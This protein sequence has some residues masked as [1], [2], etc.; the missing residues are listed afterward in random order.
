MEVKILIAVFSSQEF[1]HTR[2]SFDSSIFSLGVLT[3]QQW[4]SCLLN[5]SV[6]LSSLPAQLYILIPFGY[7]WFNYLF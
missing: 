1:K 2:L 6:R 5:S 7:N 4:P 3:V